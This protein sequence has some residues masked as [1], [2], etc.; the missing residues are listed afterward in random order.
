MGISFVLISIFFAGTVIKG[1]FNMGVDFVGGIKIIAR[2]DKNIDEAKI[3]AA[4]L[5]FGPTVQKIGDQNDYIISTKLEKD[6]A[7]AESEESEKIKSKLTQKLGSVKILSVESV[8][9]TIGDYLRRSAWK[10]AIV[11]NLFMIIYLSFRFEFKYALGVFLSDLHDVVLTLAFCGMFGIEIN[12]PVLA[13]LLTIFGFSC[14]DTIVIFDRVRENI[15]IESKITFTEIINRSIT[16]T[17][18]RTFLTTLTVLFSVFSLYLLA[19]EG[20]REFALV[21]LVGM[22]SGVYSTIYIASPFV[23]VWEKISSR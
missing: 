3:R 14:N 5:E 21:M 13:A 8:G 9:P 22:I 20:I 15:K 7:G 11:A 1:G 2:F 12:I 10:I 16:Q 4:I 6:R 19:G 23:L 18:S 17:L